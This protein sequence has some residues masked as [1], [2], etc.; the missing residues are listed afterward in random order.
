MHGTVYPFRLQGKDESKNKA[1]AALLDQLLMDRGNPLWQDSI[2]SRL[3][4]PTNYIF[5]RPWTGLDRWRFVLTGHLPTSE[6]SDNQY[7]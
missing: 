4:I 1:G 6:Y 2:M 7:T 5:E 3:I